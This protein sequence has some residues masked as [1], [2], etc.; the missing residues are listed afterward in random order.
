MLPLNAVIHLSEFKEEY[1]VF[2]FMLQL[3]YT[4]KIA[5]VFSSKILV[6]TEKT[7]R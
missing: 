7:T 4:L 6:S 1:A 5:A 2:I 3:N